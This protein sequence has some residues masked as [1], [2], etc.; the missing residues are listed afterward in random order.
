MEEIVP[1]PT[2]AT[3]STVWYRN[4]YRAKSAIAVL[5][6]EIAGIIPIIMTAIAKPVRIARVRFILRAIVIGVVAVIEW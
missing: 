1:I 6:L 4:Q 5:G 3:Y 2:S